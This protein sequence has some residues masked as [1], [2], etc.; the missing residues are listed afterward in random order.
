MIIMALLFIIQLSVSIAALAVTSDQQ[1]A[2]LHNA[3]SNVSNK[4]KAGLQQ[5]G[6]CCGFT[7]L[8][9]NKTGDPSCLPVSGAL[10]LFN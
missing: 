5:T 10:N 3:W 8:D 7:N 6:D 1:K 4:T 9:S 2:L